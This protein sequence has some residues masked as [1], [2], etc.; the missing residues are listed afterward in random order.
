MG[1]SLRQGRRDQ[2][3][4]GR[5]PQWA[6]ETAGAVQ[7]SEAGPAG[8]R[9]RVSAAGEGR[10]PPPCGPPGSSARWRW[11]EALVSLCCRR[12]GGVCAMGDPERPEVAGPE[13][14]EVNVAAAFSQGHGHP[15][16]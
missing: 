1:G 16:R 6:G 4:A 14:E 5:V 3:C 11:P 9:G 10:T 12:S 8:R 7:P 13:L 2:A 15:R